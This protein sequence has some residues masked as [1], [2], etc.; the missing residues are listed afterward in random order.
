[1]NKWAKATVRLVTKSN[2][3]DR[4]QEIYPHEDVDRDVDEG[5]IN[6][7]KKAF[8]ARNNS[9]LLN[10]LLDLEKF[11]Y[12][13]SY[14]GF[15]RRDRKAI[16]RNP[17]TVQRICEKLYE[18]GIEGVI[19]GATSPKEANTRRG[20]QFSDWTRKKFG[21]LNI[22]DFRASK[23]GIYMLDATELEARNFCNTEMGVGISKRP[24]MV[25]KSGKK[26]V[27]G[28]AKFLSSTGGNQGR[29]F[30]DGMKLAT[31]ASG[32]AFKVFI[33]DGIHWIEKGS[34]QYRDIEYG[35][36]AVFSALLLENYL[37]NIPQR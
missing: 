35:T 19:A 29:A 14:V 4:L 21:W 17:Q 1:M 32:N 3:L 8:K 22:E 25:A 9:A 12:K 24:D 6:A 26:Y 11:P 30:E 36:A 33:L 13:D 16:S 5:T 20:N 23:S 10:K 7:I 34:E 18:M 2:Y 28:E 15:L 37:N 27:I 31:N